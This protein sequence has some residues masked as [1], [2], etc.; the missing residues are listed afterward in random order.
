MLDRRALLTG[1]AATFVSSASRGELLCERYAGLP[2]R[3]NANA[4]IPAG[5]VSLPGGRFLMGSDR[6]YP[7]EMPLR[8]VTVGPFAIQRHTVTN[9]QYRRFVAATG[10]VTVAERPLK[11]EDYPHL[12]AEQRKPGSLVFRQPS[13]VKD[14][15]DL[16]QWWQWTPGA[17]WR[18]PM[19]PGSTAPPNQPVVHVAFDDAMTYARWTGQDLPTEAEWE[20]AARGG[21]HAATYA[22]GESQ[23]PGGRPAANHWQGTFPIHDTGEDGFKGIAPVGCFAP[24]GFGLFDM[25]G[26]VWQLTKDDY[27]DSSGLRTGM[28]VVKGGSY[29]CADNFCGRYRPAA[30][31]PHGLDTGLQHVG[32]RTVWRG[33]V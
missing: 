32:F 10:Y 6:H 3:R 16:N 12:T 14:L 24:N 33:S 20:Y 30:R 26:N 31:S 9:A 29:L 5:M 13:A 2:N 27:A 4:G 8:E 7:E 15:V 23:R 17:S 18:A 11:A 21:L 19:G 22:W 28:K 25:T 1:F